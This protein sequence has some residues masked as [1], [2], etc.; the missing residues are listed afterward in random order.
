MGFRP[1]NLLFLEPV[2]LQ[3]RKGSQA[4]IGRMRLA[5]ALFVVQIGPATG[6]Q[7]AAIALAYYFHRQ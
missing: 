1:E 3:S 5:T 7:S 2:L 4:R 6:A